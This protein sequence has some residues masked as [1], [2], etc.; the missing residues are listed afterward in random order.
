MNDALFKKRIEAFKEEGEL[1]AFNLALVA[2]AL[3]T[4]S[5]L[6]EKNIGGE[7][8]EKRIVS[9]YKNWDPDIFKV[10]KDTE[11]DYKKRLEEKNSPFVLL[12]EEVER[13]EINKDKDGEIM[14]VVADPFDGSFLFKRGIP[15][16]WYS[17][18]AFYDKNFNPVSC[19]V[20]DAVQKVLAFANEKGAFIAKLCEDRFIYKFKLDKNYREKMGRKDIT[21]LNSASIESYA[22]KPAKF[23]I[24]LVDEYREFIKN[25]KFLLPNGGPYGFADVAEGKIDVYFARRQ[26]F[27]D[28]FSGLYLAM[29]SEVIVTDFDGN[30]VKCSD[31]IRGLYDVVVS[32][33]KTLHKKVL[34][35]IKECKPR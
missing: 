5:E 1:T 33:N 4:I 2:E 3:D 17:S 31:N 13:L 15:D 23:L 22:M 35:K 34:A 9:E 29:Q 21:E 18:L 6:N 24:P 7:I 19:V 28:V 10:D 8:V 25:F 26:P 30:P 16:F 20:G 11:N 27:V 32:A 14:Y 12:S